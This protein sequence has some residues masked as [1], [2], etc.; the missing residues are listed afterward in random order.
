MAIV[1]S[2]V[3]GRH[4]EARF[5][6]MIERG[7]ARQAVVIQKLVSDARARKDYMAGRQTLTFVPNTYSE[8]KHDVGELLLGF[9]MPELAD[10]RFRMT[11]WS[12]GQVAN[13]LSVPRDF[14]A[15]LIKEMPTTAADLMM[16]LRQRM[17]SRFLVRTIGGTVK[18]I[19]SERY[20]PIDQE[21]IIADFC[22]V[23]QRTGA[24]P[25][26]GYMTECRFSLKAAI[27]SVLNPLPNEY[28]IIG[29]HLSSSDY[30]A[31]AFDTRVFEFRIVCT[32]MA[33]GESL[34]RQ[35]HHGG[36][37]GGGDGEIDWSNRTQSLNQRTMLSAMQDAMESVLSPKRRALIEDDWRR[38][39]QAEIDSRGELE[40]LRRGGILRKPEVDQLDKMIK[41]ETRIEVL[42]VT[43]NPQSKLRLQQALAWLGSQEKEGERK[44]MLELAAGRVSL[45]ARGTA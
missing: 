27:G 16:D 45:R 12:F 35:V 32:N 29:V 19:L 17:D 41:E 4:V 10:A 20:K 44:H 30:G 9:D 24:V 14:L 3:H 23:C 13:K 2:A 6:E 21:K 42:P 43:E 15:S 33:V 8:G 22:D 34:F 28:V 7:K 38:L 11:D 18:G 40:R 31:G 1:Q 39:A 5:E 37:L 26:D 25:L 36:L